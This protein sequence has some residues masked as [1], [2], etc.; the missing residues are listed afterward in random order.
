M[1]LGVG[2]LE[3]VA[4]VGC[5]EGDGQFLRDFHQFFIDE[6]LLGNPV[7]HHLEVVIPLAEDLVILPGRCF[8][9]FEVPFEDPVGDLSVQ[10]CTRGD[11]PLAVRCQEFLVDA[12]S[13]VESLQKS[14]RGEFHQISVTL[15]VFGQYDQVTCRLPRSL[16]RFVEPALR[17]HVEFAADDGL[18]PGLVSLLVEI[19]G[20]VHVAV[21]RDGHGGHLV[22]PCHLEEIGKADGTVEETVLGVEVEVDEIGVLH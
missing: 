7:L 10:A 3:V 5:N 20:S 11:E 2:P 15:Q 4:V 1:G 8:G 13:V 9:P 6:G 18:D 16:G 14:G 22:V 12:R 21:V 17:R 19:N